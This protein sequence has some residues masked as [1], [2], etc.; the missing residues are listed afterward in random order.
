MIETYVRGKEAIRQVGVLHLPLFPF[1][2]QEQ[3]RASSS[4]GGFERPRTPPR[5]FQPAFFKS[6]FEI[7]INAAEMVVAVGMVP[8]SATDATSEMVAFENA[9]MESNGLV[10]MH[11]IGHFAREC[12]E[13]TGI[14][15]PDPRDVRL[16]WR[17]CPAT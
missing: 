9:V 6:T 15:R 17:S 8:A 11:R 5:F 16:V 12:P 10:G 7:K 14:R 13:F 4:R 2:L 3:E 1:P